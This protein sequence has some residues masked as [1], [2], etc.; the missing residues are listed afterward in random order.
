MKSLYTDYTNSKAAD[1]VITVPA[2]FDHLQRESV[3]AAAEAAGFDVLSLLN[4]P[5][6]AAVYYNNIGKKKRMNSVWCLIWVAERL[7]SAL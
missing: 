5:T 6:A 3:R 4:E 1:A 2:Y 7:I